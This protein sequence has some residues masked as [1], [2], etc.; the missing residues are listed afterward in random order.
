VRDDYLPG[1]LASEKKNRSASG[2]T[3]STEAT[4][5]VTAVRSLSPSGTR[6]RPDPSVPRGEPPHQRWAG[7]RPPRQLAG[8]Q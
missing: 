5:T 4:R 8:E 1:V 6:T 2:I 3:P 7:E